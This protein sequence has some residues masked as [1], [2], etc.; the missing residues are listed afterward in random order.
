MD[1]GVKRKLVGAGVL[2]LVALIVL[3]QI[4][5]KTQNAEYLSKT[6][7]LEKNIPSMEMPLPK[8]LA[9]PVDP[10]I[11][12]EQS[13]GDVVN[14]PVMKVDDEI[15]PA[16]Q[17]DVPVATATGEAV[18]WQIQVGSFSKRDNALKLRDR[19]REAGYKAFEQFS[20]DGQFTRV[21]IGPSTQKTAMEQKMLSIKQ[22]FKLDAQLVPFQNQ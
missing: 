20:A 11:S 9:I 15:L 18:V 7:P 13:V 8:S 22:E 10:M 19:L 12:P 1:E 6:V 14:I 2:V 5:R 16:S 21:F 4:S 3:P 17:F